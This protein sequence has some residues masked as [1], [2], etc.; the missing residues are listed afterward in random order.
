VV[1]GY[2]FLRGLKAGSSIRLELMKYA[3]IGYVA[4][5]EGY[6]RLAL[7]ALVDHGDPYVDRICKIENLRFDCHAVLA[8]TKHKVSLGAYVAHMVSLNNL[9][10][11]NAVFSTILGEDFIEAIKAIDFMFQD[12]GKK[13]QLKMPLFA[14][15]EFGDLEELFRLRHVFAHEIAPKEKVKPNI[16][17]DC[18][19]AAAAF[20][21][22]FDTLIQTK[23]PN[24]T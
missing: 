8:I 11:I 10:D 5:L 2:R 13:I 1:A 16:I 14:D 15:A 17:Q 21:I 23:I 18:I 12:D 20:S 22:S 19:G 24:E 4:C 7:K 6:L 9:R 3:P